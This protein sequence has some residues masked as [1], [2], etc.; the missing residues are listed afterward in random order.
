MIFKKQNNKLTDY[1]GPELET[2]YQFK[3]NA[4]K[5]V[6]VDNL[7]YNHTIDTVKNRMYFRVMRSKRAITCYINT[8][9]QREINRN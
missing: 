4:V 5:G 9:N 2:E 1:I 6:C 7:H 3:I 8:G